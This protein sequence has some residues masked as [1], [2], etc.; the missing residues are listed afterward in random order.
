M[1]HIFDYL[2]IMILK[3][4]HVKNNYHRLKFYL[5]QKKKIGSVFYFY[6]KLKFFIIQKN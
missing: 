4:M 3:I 1:G 6:Y 2:T 5:I